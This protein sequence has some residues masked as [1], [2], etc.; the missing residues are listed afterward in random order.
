MRFPRINAEGQSFYH[1]V[2]R[3]V[4]RQFIFQTADH[5]S[6]EAERFVLLMRR[7]E[8]FSGVRV[9]TYALMS[10]HFHLLCEVPQAQELSEAELLERIQAGYGPARRQALDQQLAHLRQEPDGADQI[11]RLLQPYRNRL[12]DIS[13]FVK[14][15]KGR[16]AQWY[17]RRHG[18][19]G[20][21][22]AERS[23]K[24]L[25][26]RFFTRSA[27]SVSSACLVVFCRARSQFHSCLLSL[28]LLSDLSLFVLRVPLFW[29][30][31]SLFWGCAIHGERGR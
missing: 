14:E 11:Q 5:G 19:Y 2:S 21:L 13:I 6:P 1:C 30:C 29:V 24:I 27:F 15:L 20:V 25:R 31:P 4:D 17:N 7:L 9:L 16:F 10:N 23:V 12:F 22:C 28:S 26:C 8:A 3:V 18:R